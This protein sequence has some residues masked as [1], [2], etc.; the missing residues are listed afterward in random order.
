MS[1]P[2]TPACDVVLTVGNSLMGDDGAGPLLC[3]RMETDPV[4]GWTVID[5]GSMPENVTYAVRAMKPRRLLIVDAAALGL[6]PGEMRF[7]DK[8]RISELGLGGTHNLPLSFLMNDLEQDV[9]Q[10]VFLGIQPQEVGFY[11]PMSETVRAAVEKIHK[12]LASGL[13][14]I[15]W[16]S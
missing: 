8:T 6:Q 5:G 12:G 9:E 7:V 10:V 13:N 4:P 3:E 1:M 11:L 16:L 14:E 2:A 15:P